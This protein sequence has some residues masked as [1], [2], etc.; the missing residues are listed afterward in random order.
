M[1]QDFKELKELLD[2]AFAFQAAMANILKDGKVT[3]T[4]ARHFFPVLGKV[5]PAFKD[6]GNPVTR[7]RAL[8]EFE[9][10]MLIDFAEENFTLP[11][12]ALEA[13]IEDT[14]EEIVDDIRIINRWKSFRKSTAE[15]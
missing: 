4:D 9:R 15:E 7:L 2:F 10:D 14:L 11:R 12:Q 8:P 1:S 3:W 6:I 5:K 13:L